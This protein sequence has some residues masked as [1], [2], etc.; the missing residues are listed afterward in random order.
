M[1]AVVCK[2]F[3]EAQVL[4]IEDIEQ[5]VAKADQVLIKIHATTV[6]AG[7]C[8]IRSLRLTFVIT[9]MLRIFAKFKRLILGMELAGEVVAVGNKVTLFKTGDH[10]FAAPGFNT[11]AQYI[12]MPEKGPLA[13]KPQCMNFEEAAALSVGGLNALHFLRKANIIKGSKVLIYGASGSIGTFAIQLAKYYGAEV[14]AVCS[15]TNVDLVKSLSADFVIDYTQ[16]DFSQNGISYDVI[17]DT[18]GKS[19]FNI[20]LK[21]LSD[22]GR[23]LLAAPRPTQMIKGLWLLLTSDKRVFFAFANHDAEILI[24]L[25]QLV[26]EGHLRSFIDKSYPL[27]EVVNAHQYVEKGHKK[28]NVV[29]TVS[30]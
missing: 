23:Y 9:L 2:N 14:T 22:N 13:L 21:S 24:A 7:D 5:P 11:Y 17:F 16:E 19:N 6:T 4:S 8:E 18:L 27:D 29:L 15:G 30:H 3:G 25:K 26:E 28:G 12:C 10:V 1:K 20:G